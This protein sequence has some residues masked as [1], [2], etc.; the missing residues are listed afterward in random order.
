MGMPTNAACMD[1]PEAARPA[2]AEL[3]AGPCWGEFGWLVAVWAPWLRAKALDC[4]MVVLCR[5]GEEGL[6]EDFAEVKALDVEP[7]SIGVTRQHCQHAWRGPKVLAA[8]DYRELVSGIQGIDLDR[9]LTPYDLKEDRR[10]GVP[11]APVAK[12]HRYGDEAAER[13]VTL[14]HARKLSKHPEY[15]WS[16]RNWE[17]LREYLPDDVLAIGSPGGAMCPA[18]YEDARGLS[19]RELIGL[20]SRA[21]VVIGP[22]SGP[23]PLANLCETPVVWWAPVASGPRRYGE[24]WNPFSVQNL[25]VAPTWTPSVEQV[26]ATL[27][28][29]ARPKR[30]EGRAGRETGRL[31]LLLPPGIGDIHWCMLKMQSLARALNGSHPPEVSVCSM[32]GERDRAADYLRKVPFVEFAGYHEMQGHRNDFRR[33]FSDGER[34]ENYQ[35][36]DHFYGYNLPVLHGDPPGK[37]WPEQCEAAFDYPLLIS[38][39]ER[40]TEARAKAQGPYVLASFYRAGWYQRWWDALRP[41]QIL[42]ELRLALPE[43]RI[44]LTGASWDAP[45]MRELADATGAL[46]LAGG[47]SIDELFGLIRGASVYVGH[48]AGNTMMS[49]H[50]RTPTAIVWHPDT[51]VEGMWTCWAPPGEQHYRTLDAKARTPREAAREVACLAR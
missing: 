1:G 26:A 4:E 11:V 44:I 25:L 13:T 50:L 7:G 45:L 49:V 35:G 14:I 37:W 8:H 12:W 32:N 16:R 30:K 47:T 23:L 39:R 24:A 22:S 38:D 31:R 15:N 6:F 46:S 34:L 17:D 29:S 2:A 27:G 40:E 36:F 28:Y 41:D 51:F 3:Y 18:G 43:H 5:P 10:S 42:K 20:M 33:V 48:A 21:R 9:L 19:L